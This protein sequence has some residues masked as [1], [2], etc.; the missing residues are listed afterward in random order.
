MSNPV[1]RARVWLVALA[2]WLLTGCL[3]GV[4]PVPPQPPR[5]PSGERA[6]VALK[7]YASGLAA[8]FQQT[9]EQLESG[10]LTT[11]AAAHQ[12]LSE[13]HAAAR[14]AAFAPLDK[15]LQDELGDD[16][17]EPRRASQL[18]RALATD[19]AQEAR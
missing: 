8:S 10:R 4:N 17:W 7:Q 13:G 15:V 14:K 11:A 18:F 2:P 19:F 6:G 5:P 3:Q 9:A 16:R 1:P 12:R